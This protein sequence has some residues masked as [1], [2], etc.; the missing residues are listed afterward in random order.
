[1]FDIMSYDADMVAE[2]Q[3]RMEALGL[4]DSI[5]DGYR[6][7]GDIRV[8]EHVGPST[9]YCIPEDVKTTALRG[10]VA[11]ALTRFIQDQPECLPYLITCESTG[12]GMFAD[13]YYV[14][15]D[16]DEWQMD[17]E[18][19]QDGNP[20]VFVTNLDQPDLSEFGCINIDVRTVDD[21][22]FVYRT[23]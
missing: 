19:I 1:M 14:S 20:C 17:N 16:R 8:F 11:M 22:A 23:A 6:E 7:R 2:A 15:P 18:D 13:I 21:A 10:N 4:T 9:S 12:L 3:H 5:I